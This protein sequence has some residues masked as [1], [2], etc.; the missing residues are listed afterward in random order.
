MFI[1]CSPTYTDARNDTHH[2]EKLPDD[3]LQS[4]KT[5]LQKAIS[6]GHAMVAKQLLTADAD[7]GVRKKVGR[8]K[9]VRDQIVN[10]VQKLEIM[11]SRIPACFTIM[12]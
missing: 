9:D 4:G 11:G 6:A 2:H 7:L 8:P 5:A 10:Y 1:I 12:S 3:V